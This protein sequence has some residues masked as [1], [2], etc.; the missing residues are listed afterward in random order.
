MKQSIKYF[1]KIFLYPLFSILQLGLSNHTKEIDNPPAP[2][3]CP[4]DTYTGLS[5]HHKGPTFP[6]AILQYLTAYLW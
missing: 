3:C 5:W 2:A 4:T 1:L 6:D